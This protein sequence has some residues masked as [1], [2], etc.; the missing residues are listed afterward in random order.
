MTAL[1]IFKAKKFSLKDM[2]TNAGLGLSMLAKGKLKFVPPAIKG[3]KALRV[4]FKK[5]EGRRHS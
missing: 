3:T 5:T 4:I 1:F 2:L